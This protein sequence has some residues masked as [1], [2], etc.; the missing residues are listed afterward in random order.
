MSCM[1]QKLCKLLPCA[2]FIQSAKWA[3]LGCQKAL[4]VMTEITATTL[5]QGSISKSE[6]C[7]FTNLP[8]K[9]V[10]GVYYVYFTDGKTEAW[11]R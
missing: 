3:A 11:R 4:H 1:E 8:T 5:A 6:T 7:A 9:H 10:N 2:F